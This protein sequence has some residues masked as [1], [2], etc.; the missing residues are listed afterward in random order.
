MCIF[1]EV[2]VLV[3]V[4]L[5]FELVSERSNLRFELQFVVSIGVLL[6]IL[7]LLFALTGETNRSDCLMRL[8]AL[9]S[10]AMTIIAVSLCDVNSCSNQF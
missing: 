9:I 10:F 3:V 2:D 1:L 7:L 4:F 6:S 5:I 8:V